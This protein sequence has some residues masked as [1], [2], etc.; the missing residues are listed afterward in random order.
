MTQDDV[1]WFK[2]VGFVSM[3][4]VQGLDPLVLRARE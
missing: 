4:A 3:T 1:K 2:G